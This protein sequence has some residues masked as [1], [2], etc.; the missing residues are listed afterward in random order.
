MTLSRIAFIIKANSWENNG[1]L[2]VKRYNRRKTL[3][4]NQKYG[5]IARLYSCVFWRE[6]RFSISLNC[7]FLFH[8]SS[9][10]PEMGGTR[11]AD[12]VGSIPAF[13]AGRAGSNPVRRSTAGNG[14]H[15][16]CA[17]CLNIRRKR[18]KF[19]LLLFSRR[20]PHSILLSLLGGWRLHKPPRICRDTVAWD[21][22]GNP[23]KSMIGSWKD[24]TSGGGIDVPAFLRGTVKPDGR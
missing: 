6:V 24:G 10:P 16:D 17:L 14:L 23:L 20:N 9:I 15:T 21:G 1:A 3:Q 13:Q 8:L 7:I 5:L 22:R 12:V 4:N 19:P 11:A 18:W 2:R